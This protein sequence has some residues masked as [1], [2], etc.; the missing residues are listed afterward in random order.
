MRTVETLDELTELVRRYSGL[1]VRWSRG[2]AAD[3]AGASSDDLTGEPLP[4]TPDV[5][6]R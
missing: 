3:A 1:F 4:G 2:P 5:T 6:G